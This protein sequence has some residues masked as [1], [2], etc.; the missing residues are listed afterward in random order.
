MEKISKKVENIR[1]EGET[2]LKGWKRCGCFGICDK[3]L[4]IRLQ[5]LEVEKDA[6]QKEIKDQSHFLNV[7]PVK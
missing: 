4:E 1:K 6:I 7:F 3:E 2:L 5:K